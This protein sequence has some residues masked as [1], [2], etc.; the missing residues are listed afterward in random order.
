MPLQAQ[1]CSCEHLSLIQALHLKEIEMQ[2]LCVMMMTESSTSSAAKALV[3]VKAC[4]AR[5]EPQFRECMKEMADVTELEVVGEISKILYDDTKGTIKSNSDLSKRPADSKQYSSGNIRCS[6]TRRKVWIS[7]RK[8]IKA[9]RDLHKSLANVVNREMKSGLVGGSDFSGNAMDMKDFTEIHNRLASIQKSAIEWENIVMQYYDC[10]EK[11]GR[12]LCKVL[13]EL[14]KRPMQGS[15]GQEDGMSSL[16][17]EMR[18]SCNRALRKVDASVI[19]RGLEE[20]CQSCATKFD[21]VMEKISAAAEA[22]ASASDASKR[23]IKGSSRIFSKKARSA[24]KKEEHHLSTDS[25]FNSLGVSEKKLASKV[26]QFQMLAVS[27]EASLTLQSS[28]TEFL[29]LTQSIWQSLYSISLRCKDSVEIPSITPTHKREVLESRGQSG[30]KKSSKNVSTV[31]QE[32]SLQSEKTKRQYEGATRKSS[33][34]RLEEMLKDIQSD[35]RLNRKDDDDDDSYDDDGVKDEKECELIVEKFGN[36]GVSKSHGSSTEL[37][38][39]VQSES[40]EDGSSTTEHT[41]DVSTRDV[42]LLKN[43]FEYTTSEETIR[44]IKHS[45]SFSEITVTSSEFASSDEMESYCVSSSYKNPFG[46]PTSN[47]DSGGD[48]EGD[49]INPFG[50]YD[51][52]DVSDIG[53]DFGDTNVE[54]S[55][56][57][58]DDASDESNDY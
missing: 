44:P 27:R 36:M 5:I 4:G 3:A 25:E 52:E 53:T 16:D 31:V 12:V 18:S 56:P 30:T 9:Q 50:T 28:I 37:Q 41:N 57:F 45:Q 17:N 15:S 6:V 58:L 33:I 1:D 49:S 10:I 19:V 46:S 54:Q 22:K 2:V 13:C 43:P 23:N 20:R 42:K 47:H 26:S 21:K 24:D 35:V 8:F 32:Y 40:S 7:V 11:T 39:F 48:F 34:R 55:N 14:Y 29:C 51:S 38:K